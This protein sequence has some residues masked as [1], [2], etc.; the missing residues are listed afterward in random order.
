MTTSQGKVE[1]M[2]ERAFALALERG[3]VRQDGE[4]AFT[5]GFLAAFAYVDEE[6][7]AYRRHVSNVEQLAT[8][9]LSCATSAVIR[10]PGRPAILD[11][12]PLPE[13]KPSAE[14]AHFDPRAVAKGMFP[15]HIDADGVLYADGDFIPRAGG[16]KLDE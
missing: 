9:A 2:A 7:A 12:G 13:P 1:I 5:H 6:M 10:I 14:P 15:T 3:E 8:R 16:S 11:A 4:A